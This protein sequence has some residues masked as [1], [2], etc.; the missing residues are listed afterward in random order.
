MN[1]RTWNRLEPLTGVVGSLL[2]FVGTGLYFAD[3]PKADD[4]A[5]DFVKYIVDNRESILTG[6]VLFMFGGGFLLWWLGTLRATLSSGDARTARW[7]TISLLGGAVGF[8]TVFVGGSTFTTLAWRGPDGLSP[9]LVRVV[10]DSLQVGFGVMSAIPFTVMI[11]AATLAMGRHTAFPTWLVWVGV[12]AAV[13]NG[14]GVF[15]VCARTGVFSPYSMLGFPGAVLFFGWVICAS[16]IM[17][18]RP[19]S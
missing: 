1:D 2:A 19:T 8:A 18:R 15:F 5:S 3:L 9:E 14:L 13:L 17:S 12:A 10:I 16:V 11:L 7:A 4:P 6:T